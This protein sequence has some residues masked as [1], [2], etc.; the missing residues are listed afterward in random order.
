MAIQFPGHT[1]PSTGFEVPL[2]M[3]EACHHRVQHQCETLLRLPAHLA[4]NGADAAARR[5]AVA[6]IRYF[7]TAAQDH[8]AD[9]ES[10]LFPALIESMA[11]RES[12]QLRELIEGLCTEHRAL[13]GHWRRLRALLSAISEGQRTTLAQADVTPLTE[14]YARHIAREEAELL[15]MAARMLDDAALKRV[16]RAMRTRRGIEWVE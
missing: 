13:E 9:E 2:E 7:D 11:D 15:P 3:L 10:D 4:S 6:V 8:H 1:A 12:T 5:A 16:G 14:L